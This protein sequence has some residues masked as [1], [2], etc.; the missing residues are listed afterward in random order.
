MMH[1]GLG[2]RGFYTALR[3]EG[4]VIWA[5]MLREFHT[6]QGQWGLKFISTFVQ[7]AIIVTL[8]TLVFTLAGEKSPLGMDVAP[9]ILSG[10][11]TYRL[12]MFSYSGVPRGTKVPKAAA[13]FPQVTL[14]D[15]VIT[16]GLVLYFTM[17][18]V[19]LLITAVIRTL[20]MGPW[21][22]TWV[23]L[24]CDMALAGLL[25]LS[26]GLVMRW[27]TAWLP[28]LNGMARV[29]R[30]LMHFIGGIFFIPAMI[31]DPY[32]E[33]FLWNPLVHV[34]EAARV[35]WF[36]FNDTYGSEAYVAWW[37][38]G[39]LCFGL[40]GERAMPNKKRDTEGD[41]DEDL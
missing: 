15:T 20:E 6:R 18:L 40:L 31:P 38:L 19:V 5:L 41:E 28:M 35:S 36:A 24:F 33:Y 12:F 25:G 7:T 34:T 30:H 10:F 8:L 13:A 16:T 2:E 3:S 37:I 14:L 11:V 32:R 26:F 21:P 17:I 29:I 27:A 4:R 22:V 23:G 1:P 39:M 9:F